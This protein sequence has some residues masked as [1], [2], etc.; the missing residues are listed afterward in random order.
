MTPEEFRDQYLRGIAS[1][2]PERT[3]NMERARHAILQAAF[4][5]VQNTL[6]WKSTI[7]ALVTIHADDTIGIGVYQAAIEYFTGTKPNIYVV[8]GFNEATKTA[9]YR[10]VSEGYRL[11]GAGDH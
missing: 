1:S 9:T 6:D 3:V 8:D 7:N 5:Q 2:A 4:E 11:G 10:L